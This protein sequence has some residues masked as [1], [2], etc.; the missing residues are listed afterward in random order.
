MHLKR[1]ATAAFALTLALAAWPAPTSA[2][3]SVTDVLR[4]LVTNQA[5]ETGSVERDASAARATSD[6]IARALLANLAT[7]PVPS[8]SAAFVYR[9]NP[10][11][12]TVERATGTFGP[13]LIQTALTAGRGNAGLGLTFQHLRFNALDG[14]DLRTGTLVTTA[15]QFVDEPQPFDVDALT[16]NV[17]A[18]IVTLYGSV[19]LGNRVEIGGAAPFVSL[20]LNGSRVNTYRGRTFTQ[21]SGSAT[22]LGLADVLARGKINIYDDGGGRLSAGVDVR[23]P[24][25][26][27]DDLLGTGRTAVR[28]SAIG[29][30]QGDRVTAHANAGYA[31]GGLAE[32]LLYGFALSGAATPRLTLTVEALG[33]V[34]DTPGEIVSAALPHP[35]LAGVMTTRLS[36]G[37]GRLQTLTLA[38]GLKWNVADTWVLVASVGVPLNRSGLRAAVVPFVGLDYSVGR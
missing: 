21:A 17:D 34:L 2:Q 5:I 13:A 36:P 38:P 10:D 1:S 4:F 18:D 11:I 19:G 9:L 37:T 31:I 6:T 28:F 26:R 3:N 16:L 35:T 30:W 8:T 24:T 15:N 22:A 27:Q 25:G 23:L 14:H 20:R 33:R 7:L 29:T 12:G 32:E